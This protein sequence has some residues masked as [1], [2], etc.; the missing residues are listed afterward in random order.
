MP[1]LPRDAKLLR[2]V[3]PNAG[4]EADYRRRLDAL[5]EEMAHSLDYWLGATYKRNEPEIAQDA[6]WSAGASS[7][8]Q[9][10]AAAISQLRDRWLARFDELAWG[11]AEHF[12]LS[13][14]A[15]SD[16]ALTSMLR[17]GGFS[18]KFRMTAAQK[19]I[20]NATVNQ[21]VAMI[22]SIPQQYLTDVEGLVMRSVQ[23]G[24]D[25]G[26]LR[27]DLLGRYDIT[28]RRAALIARD[29]NNKATSALQR[30]R[31]QELG[32]TEAI[33]VH[34]GGGREPRP[35]HLAKNGKRYNVA[36]GWY[37]PAEGRHIWP[38]ELINCRCTSRAVMPGL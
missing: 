29:Q 27:E 3:R 18:V 37:D 6:G 15:R 21:N 14:A 28:K 9:R 12:A 7:P 19:D 30:A 13:A 11:L 17:R 22:K 34:S 2:P 26:Q 20:I 8:A 10:L 32:I 25:L 5:I 1:R 24:R 36:E 31:Q 23:T 4:V 35:T 38:G 16:A 33:W